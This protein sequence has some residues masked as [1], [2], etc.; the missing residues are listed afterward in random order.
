MTHQEASNA[1]TLRDDEG[2]GVLAV[3]DYWICVLPNASGSFA[4]R[5]EAYAWMEE[6]DNAE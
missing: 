4:T 5:E 2:Y 6:H 1:A 3:D